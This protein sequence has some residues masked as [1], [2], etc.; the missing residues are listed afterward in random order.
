M[1]RL[2]KATEAPNPQIARFYK[3]SIPVLIKEVM[4]DR[5]MKARRRG[6]KF[7]QTRKKKIVISRIEQ[8]DRSFKEKFLNLIHVDTTSVVKVTLQAVKNDVEKTLEHGPIYFSERTGFSGDGFDALPTAT[9]QA[10]VSWFDLYKKALDS[11]N[12]KVEEKDLSE[13]E[14]LSLGILGGWITG[15]LFGWIFDQIG[16]YNPF[17]EAI[18]RFFAGSGDTIGGFFVAFR[19]RL[20]FKKYTQALFTHRKKIV[21]QI[22]D[23]IKRWFKG[24]RATA[25]RREQGEVQTFVSG[26]IIGTLFAPIIHLATLMLGLDISG[27]GGAFYAAAYSNADN[28]GGAISTIRL[29]IRKFGVNKGIRRFVSHPFQI[30]NLIVISS[31]LII[32]IILR[33]SGIWRPSNYLAFALEGMLLNNDSSIA[34]LAVWVYSLRIRRKLRTTAISLINLRGDLAR[35][36]T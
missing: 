30:A 5:A 32:N 12:R 6:R 27:V 31:F 35:I 19:E 26:A 36:V 22:S 34:S 33:A 11:Y 15:G 2:F 23:K 14:F 29:N 18:V 10:L 7:S 17:F 25:I 20:T 3:R 13:Y 28:W 24:D 1:P 8:L 21:P 4:V 16:V 9:K